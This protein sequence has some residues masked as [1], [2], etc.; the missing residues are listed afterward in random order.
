[1][2]DDDDTSVNLLIPPFRSTRYNGGFLK[3]NAR[4][5]IGALMI[6]IFFLLVHSEGNLSNVQ[7]QENNISEII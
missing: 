2:N 6:G 5:I 7:K 4:F 3:Y 1:M